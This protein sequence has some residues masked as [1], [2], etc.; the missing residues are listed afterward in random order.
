VR[1]R[2]ERRMLRKQLGEVTASAAR[3]RDELFACVATAADVALIEQNDEA[4]ASGRSLRLE[5]VR[6]IESYIDALGKLTDVDDRQPIPLEDEVFLRLLVAHHWHE[7][8]TI[9]QAKDALVEE[10]ARRSVGKSDA[11]PNTGEV[12]VTFDDKD[13]KRLD[14][15]ADQW[16]T[17]RNGAVKQ[18]IRQSA[19]ALPSKDVAASA[20]TDKLLEDLGAGVRNL[21]S[22]PHSGPH[23]PY[24]DHE[25]MRRGRTLWE[26]SYAQGMAD[27]EVRDGIGSLNVSAPFGDEIALF[28]AK[29]AVHAFQRLMTSHTFAA[30]LMCSDV[31]REVLT[32]I[33][34]QWD[35]FMVLVPNG[36]LGVSKFEFSRILVAT[37]SFGAR[38]TMLTTGG[39]EFQTQAPFTATIA[40]EAPT[41][42]DLL[43]SDGSD[44]RED[45]GSRR[46]LIMAKR[47]VAGLL[48]NLQH[49]PNFK[50]RSVEARPR[51]KGRDSDPEHRIITVGKPLEIDCRA[52]VKEC[53]SSAVRR[54]ASTVHRPCR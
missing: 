22:V 47:L 12:S 5:I 48:L 18:I 37:Y 42:S 54:V 8:Q 1:H 6:G 23:V 19:L 34:K 31:Q 4:A 36:M 45:V 21:R 17:T 41:L 7:V 39:P 27:E 16:N 14:T 3:L 24:S 53:T 30:A 26:Q 10:V 13:I 40:D 51:N 15:L 35:A 32:G 2:N 49:E 29:W 44:L 50:V 9:D 11:L 20:T 52:S 33:E 25:L 46:C 43:V 38:I 28:A